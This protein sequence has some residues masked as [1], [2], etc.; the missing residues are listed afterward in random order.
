MAESGSD[1]A[2]DRI[3]ESQSNDKVEATTR[4]LGPGSAASVTLNPTVGLAA[5][6]RVLAAL[7]A[8]GVASMPTWVQAAAALYS[9]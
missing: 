8:G 7:V 1:E 9:K 4:R 6:S 5:E 2:N 3:D